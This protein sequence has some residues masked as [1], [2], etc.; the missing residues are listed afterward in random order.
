MEGMSTSN[1]ITTTTSYETS[2]EFKYAQTSELARL[3]IKNGLPK[4][5]TVKEVAMLFQI[6]SESV[7]RWEKRGLIK[8]TRVRKG[9]RTDRRFKKEEVLRI[10]KEGLLNQNE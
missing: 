2:Y 3:F 5:L 8:A 6:H 1:S 4:Y 9:K 10:L 7:R